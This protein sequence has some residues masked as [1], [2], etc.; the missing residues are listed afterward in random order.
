MKYKETSQNLMESISIKN[1]ILNDIALLSNVEILADKIIRCYE[2]GGKVFFCGNGGSF[3]DA[4][5][6]AAELSGRFKFDRKSLEVVLLA[7]NV[8]YLTAV[9]NDY[10]YTDIFVRE[11]SA[12]YKNGD[13]V[14][15]FTTSGN[16][17]NILKLL[18]FSRANNIETA[19]FTGKG[20]GKCGGLADILIEIPS[21]DTARIQECHMI[22]GHTICE[23][24]ENQK[25]K[26]K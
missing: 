12:S 26:N 14:L 19:C 24:I 8:S 13:I 9:S 5:H 21:V 11:F 2:K 16:S 3:A 22:L 23:I 4:Q 20:G 10:D 15:C 17:K 7:S 1:E 6:L 25:F 18:E